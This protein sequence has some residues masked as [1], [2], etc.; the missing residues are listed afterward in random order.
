VICIDVDCP[1]V[2]GSMKPRTL[3]ERL[4]ALFVVPD[5]DRD[6]ALAQF[7]A[8]SKQIPLL[9]TIL[10]INTLA[11]SYS[12]AAF[13][14]AMLAVVL[15]VLLS[16]FCVL[17]CVWWYAQRDRPVDAAEAI[18]QL[19]R[20][21]RLAFLLAAGFTA[22]G[23]ALYPYGDAYARG[24]VSFYMSITVIGCILCLMHLRSAAIVVTLVVLG[25][26]SLFLLHD[27]EPTQR[28]I[29]VNMVLVAAAMMRIL[30]VNY[31]DFADLIVS[32]RDLFAE[33]SATRA[34]SDE[35]F[36][37]AN[38][39]ALTDLPNRR[40]FF[41]DVDVV[42]G[43]DGDGPPM[44]VG[45]ID[46]DGFKPIND[47]FGH[48]T[49]DRVLTEVAGR[50]AAVCGGFR[51]ADA[52]IY[53]LGGDEFGLLV[54]GRA[55][56]ETMETLCGAIVE[57]VRRPYPVATTQARIGCSIGY[58]LRS[59]SRTTA[60]GLYECAD[61]ALYHAK[62]NHRGTAVQFTDEHEAQIRA[63]SVL[64][65]TLQAAELCTE[66]TLVF[67]PIVHLADGRITAFEALARW[68][69]PVLGPVPPG[70]F[71][72]VAERIG[73][74]GT[75]TRVLLGKALE[76]ARGWPEEI[77]LSVNLSTHDICTAEGA[78][79]LVALVR[80]GGVTPARISFEITETSVATDFDQAQRTMEM[81]KAL[82]CRIS[83]DDFGTGYSSLTYVHRFPL[84]CIKIDRS[85]VVDVEDNA[86]SRQL[87]RSLAGMTADIGLTSVVEGVETEA[88]RRIL[89]DLG[90]D[91]AQGYLFARPM[92]AA[93][94]AA[95]LG[96]GRG[97]ES[98][99]G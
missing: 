54:T 13:A 25:P 62:R 27:G 60:L 36:R 86:V 16:V 38:L 73:L 21:Q 26:Y 71:I 49:G 70:S 33:Q 57:A 78:L 82:G 53:R 1:E 29:A 69:S 59:K 46:L 22:W 77:G 94:V 93:A 3:I 19:R 18:R 40:R 72:P 81:L 45:I 80:E 85:F 15:P 24:H 43:G 7:R 42:H 56:R 84:D 17:R 14:P 48:T 35:N 2:I 10:V 4:S 32:R 67:Q 61:Y 55:D 74:I 83:L 68:N 66:L 12:F 30:F 90:C 34:L 8:F 92:P 63:Q 97:S 41:K 44:A 11:V 37:I 75:I 58:A 39:D 99:G 96:L 64:E 51:A 87:V 9:Y 52:T 89:A 76:A 23:L 6:L 88:Q 95:H 79:R 98:V 31:R 50:L 5:D 65:Q 91:M 28:A 20:T 47:T